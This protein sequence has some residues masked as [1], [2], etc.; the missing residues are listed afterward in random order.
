MPRQ[1]RVG[2]HDCAQVAQELATEAFGANGQSASLIIV[3]AQ[4]PPTELL[5][6]NPILFTKVIN[7]GSDWRLFIQ[8]DRAIS[9]NRSGSKAKGI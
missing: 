4:P 2:R 8:P 5:T 9:M 7:E 6:Q 3:E 1:K